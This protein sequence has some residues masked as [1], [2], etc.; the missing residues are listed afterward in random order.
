MMYVLGRAENIK[1]CGMDIGVMQGKRLRLRPIERKDLPKLNQ[2]KNDEAVYKNLGGGF[3]PVSVDIQEKWMDSLMDTT[4]N[5]KRFIIGTNDGEAVGMVGL[6]NIAW[7]HRT[8]ELGIFIGSADERGRGYGKEA[9]LLLEGFARRY[10][11]LRKIKA[12][13]VADN[14]AALR[15][16]EKLQ[17]CKVGEFLEERYVDGEYKSVMIMEKFIG[18]EA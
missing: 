8:C 1:V 5:N 2:W 3:L 14:V 15:M 4:G 17:F 16:Y 13:V 9:Y 18:G 11:N 10:L 12:Y 7:V 6:Y